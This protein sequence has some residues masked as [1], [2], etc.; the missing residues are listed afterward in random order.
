MGA[1]TLFFLLYCVVL[2]IVLMINCR[3]S[4]AARKIGIALLGSVLILVL[5]A[6]V[7]G[8][9]FIQEARFLKYAQRD[10]KRMVSGDELQAWAL[11]LLADP[12]NQYLK[13]NYPAP[14][15]NLYP[16]DLPLVMVERD[17]VRLAWGHVDWMAGF[18]IGPTNFVTDGRKWQPG[19]YWFYQH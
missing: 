6:T 16:G 3:G 10:A 12:E 18:A 8:W 19:I 15:R 13:T 1:L 4:A 11:K 14:L 5:A 9:P 17:S 7:L 2:G